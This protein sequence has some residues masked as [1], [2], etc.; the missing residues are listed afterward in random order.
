MRTVIGKLIACLVLAVLTTGIMMN[1]SLS[2]SQLEITVAADKAYY[3]LRENVNTYGN[4]TLDDE[5]VQE[6]LVAIEIEDPVRIFSMRTVP[7]TATPSEAWAVEI[8]SVLP[9]DVGGNEKTSFIRGAWSYFRV[10]VRNNG[11][12]PKEAVVTITIYDNN[13]IPL[14]SAF[15][16]TTLAPQTTFEFMPGLWIDEWASA[17]TSVAYA[18][19]LTDWPKNGGYPHSPEK[20]ATFEITELDESVYGQGYLESPLQNPNGTYEANLRLSPEPLPGTYLVYATAYSQGRNAFMATAFIVN[21]T[22]PGSPFPRAS[23]VY[24]PPKAGPGTEV[25]FDASSSTAEGYGDSITSYTWDFGDSQEGTG[26]IVK[27]TYPAEGNYNV[28]LNVTDSEGQWNTTSRLV[29]IETIHDVA[30]ISVECLDMIYSD[31]SVAITAVVMN[32]GTTSETFNVTAYY[33]SS[34]IEALTITQPAPF[35]KSTLTFTWNTSGITILANYSVR[36]EIDPIPDEANVTNNIL[37]YE[38]VFARMLGDVYYDR[39]ID[40]YDV[41]RVT[42]IYGKTSAA[43]GWNPQADLMPDGVIEIYDVV[44]VTAIYGTTY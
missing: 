33:N 36:V 42:V 11:V 6:G 27:H 39:T 41:V 12:T 21:S 28:A 35:E 43:P 10:L 3:W 9:S 24:T 5:P 44:K 40:I 22:Y 34:I 31:W 4:V 29:R 19:V 14:K 18:S 32:K 16:E 1:L 8:L 37:T 23:F 17:G 30:V 20:K 26:K 13:N 7:V 25:R 2:Q 38:P 15:T